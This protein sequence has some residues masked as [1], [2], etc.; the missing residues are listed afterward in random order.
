MMDISPR[1]SASDPTSSSFAAL[2]TV[3]HLETL[4]RT[5]VLRGSRQSSISSKSGAVL[6][7]WLPPDQN[8]ARKWRNRHIPTNKLSL[9]FLYRSNQFSAQSALARIIF[10]KKRLL[11]LLFSGNAT[12]TPVQCLCWS[13][14]SLVLTI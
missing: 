5:R 13:F 3:R 6:F 11:H 12:L 4:F 14:A 8:R 9:I 10:F 1:K 2:S 7:G